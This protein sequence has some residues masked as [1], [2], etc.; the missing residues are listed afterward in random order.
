MP[1]PEEKIG[2]IPGVFTSAWWRIVLAGLA[3]VLLGAIL[4]AMLNELLAILFMV[5]LA[6]SIA[7]ALAPLVSRLENRMS[8]GIAVVLVFL[9]LLLLLGLI[10]WIII[11]PLIEQAQEIIAEAPQFVNTLQGLFE[12]IV[13]PQLELG[14][15]IE[16]ITGQLQALAIAL[17]AVPVGIFSGIVAVVLLV[18]TTIYML[19]EAPAIHRSF[20]SLYPPHD[21]ERADE[22]ALK[23]A[24]AMGGFVRGTAIIAFIVGLLTYIGLLIIGVRFPLALGF[25]AGLLEFIPYIGPF[26]AA[27]P[28]VLVALMESPTQALI[29]LVFFLIVQEVE[30]NILVPKIQRTQTEVSPLMSILA[31]TA[32]SALGGIVGVLAAI[33]F[34]AAM[35]VFFQEVV[36][37]AI[38]RRTGAEGHPPREVGEADE[39]TEQKEK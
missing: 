11:P 25:L 7:A 19:I 28:I 27:I 35:R 24:N 37:P 21:R 15:I 30:A 5:I 2:N 17:L 14:P 8:R 9:G 31:L 23:M 29:V 39:N 16:S 3:I 33:P 36:A 10:L 38:R 12:D 32:G 4:I 34:V 6:A 13:G 18:F 20:L 1:S 26:L 22:V